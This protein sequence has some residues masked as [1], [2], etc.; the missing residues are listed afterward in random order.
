MQLDMQYV[1]EIYKQGGFSKAA[2]KLFISQP[3]LSMAVQKVEKSIGMPLFNRS[4]RP[5]S[6]TDAGEI[7][8]DA[9]EKQRFLEQDTALQLEDIRALKTGHITIAGTHYL[10]AYILSDIIT[11]FHQEFPYITIDLIENASAK[12]LELLQKQDIDMTFSCDPEVLPYYSGYPAFSDEILLAVPASASVNADVRNY[13]LSAEDIIKRKNLK[14][15]CPVI[16]LDRFKNED[17]ILLKEENNLYLRSMAL[18]HEYAFEPKVILKLAQ[19]VTAY[20]LAERG[21]AASFI[22]DLVVKNPS[23]ALCFYKIDSIHT[24]RRFYL[25][26]PKQ[27]YISNAV[28]AFIEYMQDYFAVRQTR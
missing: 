4:T 25:L 23:A 7:Y 5:I 8:I 15:D 21:F 22:S 9:I 28:Q 6:L 24:F 26:I 27:R 19:L 3:A 2:E 17:F 20:H 12:N 10:N 16:S 14:E 1:C 18:C 13:A 11:G